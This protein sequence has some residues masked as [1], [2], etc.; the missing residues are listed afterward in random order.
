MSAPLQVREAVP[1]HELPS[2]S[3]LSSSLSLPAPKN[4]LLFVYLPLFLKFLQKL[5][6]G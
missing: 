3:F 1:G 2:W 6:I 5:S 4:A